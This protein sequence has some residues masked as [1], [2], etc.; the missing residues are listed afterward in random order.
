MLLGLVFFVFLL[1]ALVIF[2]MNETFLEPGFYKNQM[3]EAGVYNFALVDLPTSGIEEVSSKATGF[4]SDTLT[5]NFLVSTGLTT[6]DIVSSIGV[7]VPSAW[8]QEQVEQ[9]I[10]QALS[11]IIGKQDSFEIIVMAEERVIVATDVVKILMR[12][13][14]LYDLLFGAMVRQ[15]IDETL[16]K[17]SALPF[18]VSLT[19]EDVVDAVQ[20]VATE[21]WIKYQVDQSLDGIMAYMLGQQETFEVH[22]QV[23]ERADVAIDEIK[24]L[25]MKANFFEILLDEVFDSM[26]EG[27]MPQL[28]DL[29]FGVNI[30]EEELSSVIRELFPQSWVEEQALGII[31]E[32][33]PYLIG[34]TD[35]FSVSIPLGERR[36]VALDSIENMATAKLNALVDVLPECTIGQLTFS[37]IPHSLQDLPKCIPAVFDAR[38]FI[39]L[40][41]ID[42]TGEIGEMIGVQIPDEIVY[43]EVELHQSIGGDLDSSKLDILD[44]VREIITQ[45]WTYTELDLRQDLGKDYSNVLDDVRSALSD[46]WTYTDADLRENL[47]DV[48]G[49]AA[50]VNLDTFREQLNRARYMRFLVY[51]LCAVLLVLIGFLG[52]RQWFGRIAWSAGTLSISAVILFVVSVPIYN[53]IIQSRIYEFRIDLVDGIDSPTLLLAL[54][55][56]LNIVQS[57]LD[58][59]LG[60]IGHYSLLLFA[61]SGLFWVAV[62][63]W[64]KFI[65]R[66]S[67]A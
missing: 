13:A 60:G 5:E 18:N 46:G 19:A 41:G 1:L 16:G 20:R 57:G 21:D 23:R 51:I 17:E 26:L 14:L 35:N 47:A 29:P 66:T 48:A 30:T 61:I 44:N 67:S 9:S 40:L 34:K 28:T 55:K 24:A 64:T 27:M 50:I 15:R 42:I 37:G 45:G 65:R 11:Y 56:G 36:D 52:G 33:G 3:A 59:F 62:L 12:K 4:F 25:L 22:V 54:D 10:D 43:T 6:V 38:V 49:G 7:I 8:L 2:R 39:D 63:A 58:D 32:A 31:D 53:S